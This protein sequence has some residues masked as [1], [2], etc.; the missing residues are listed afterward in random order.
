MV[1]WTDRDEAMVNWLLVVRLAE[2][3]AI[4]W[5]LGALSGSGV[6]VST[7]KAQQ[8]VV[9][10]EGAGLVERARP[11]YRDTSIVWATAAAIGR[12]A[13]NLFRQT[14]RHE[15][16]VSAVSAR[17]LAHGYTWQRDRKPVAR[18]DHQAD[19]VAI[20][21]GEAELIEVELTPKT[22]QRYKMICENHSH[23]L[24]HDGVT[25]VAYFCTEDATRAVTRAAD[26]YVFRTERPGLQAETVFDVRGQWVGPALDR[27]RPEVLP[28]ASILTELDGVDGQPAGGVTR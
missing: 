6:P 1:Q 27:P 13:P 17:Y 25:R 22:W 10:L 4:R 16:A 3:D 18:L 28:G 7:R 23:R 9:R 2:M 20:R 14:I 12:P 24:A 11:T 15:V 8:W 26:K 19:G 5:A 21:D